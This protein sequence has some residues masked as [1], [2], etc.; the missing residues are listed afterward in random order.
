MKKYIQRTLW[1]TV[2]GIIASVQAQI[3]SVGSGSYTNRFPGTDAAARNGFPSGKPFTVEKA[4]LKPPPSNDWW[5]AKIKNAHCDNLFNY[6]FTL[7]T[8]ATGLVVTYIPWGVI[9][10]IQPIIMGVS[11]MSAA[12]ADIADHTDWTIQ[13]RWK[14]QNSIFRTTTGVGMPFLYFEKDS[15]STAQITVNS[16]T[17][18]IKNNR[19]LI[20]NARNGADFVVYG[21]SGS[22]WTQNGTRITSNLNGK[23][24][25]SMALLPHDAPNVETA[26]QAYEKYAFVFPTNTRSSYHYN[27]AQS[28]VETHFKVDVN[29][30]EGT[31]S[32]MLMGLLPHQWAHLFKGASSLTSTKYRTV[33][34]DL[35]MFSGNSF[36][37]QHPFRGILPT[38]PYVDPYSKGFNPLDLK[39]KIE[40]IMNDGLAEWT[41]S[42]NEGQVMNRLIQTARIAHEMQLDQAVSTIVKTVKNPAWKIGLVPNQAK[43]LLY[44]IMTVPGNRFWDIRPDTVKTI[45]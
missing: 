5:S 39:D 7:K 16:G 42:Y 21:P 28:R 4:A 17:V 23:N 27:E 40:S 12:S 43:G 26:A 35:K 13:M 29:V 9:D 25:W 14:K 2:L 38:L 1:V 20:Q 33:R 6:P 37:T 19:V 34:G 45:T 8:V 41:D 44:F 24:Y 31:D 32:L 10:D 22:T 15:Q 36:A 30:K 3:I 11:D 18:T